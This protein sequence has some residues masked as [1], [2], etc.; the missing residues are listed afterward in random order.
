LRT[1]LSSTLL[2]ASDGFVVRDWMDTVIT[3]WKG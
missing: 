3:N 1:L 2:T